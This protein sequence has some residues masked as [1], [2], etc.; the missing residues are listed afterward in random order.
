MR[1][2]AELFAP[3]DIMRWS[4]RMT[5][6]AEASRI[7]AGWAGLLRARLDEIHGGGKE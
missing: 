5:N 4:N 7:L 1:T 3:G 6:W 2:T